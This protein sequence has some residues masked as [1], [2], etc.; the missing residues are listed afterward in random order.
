M[1]PQNDYP[2]F[3]CHSRY[4]VETGNNTGCIG[5]IEGVQEQ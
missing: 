5:T 2:R 4:K 3:D 1:R